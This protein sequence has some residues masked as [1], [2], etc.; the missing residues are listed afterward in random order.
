MKEI[1]SSFDRLDLNLLK[2]FEIV[3]RERSLSR[4]A[5]VLS[6]T[7]SAISH[8]LRRLR[9][10]FGDPLFERVGHK[11]VPTPLCNRIANDV[12]LEMARMRAMMQRW[13]YFDPEQSKG[14]LILG[15]PDALEGVFIPNLAQAIFDA[16]PQLTLVSAAIQRRSLA[17]DL[18]G[19]QFDVAIDVSLPV[20][21][22][23][24][25]KPLF[26]SDWCMVARCDHL[27]ISR[28]TLA[29]YENGKHVVVSSRSFG[30][31]LEDRALGERSINRSVQLRCQNYTTAIGGLAQTDLVLTMPRVLAKHLLGKRSDLCMVPLPVEMPEL[32]LFLYWHENH[33][34][35][36]RSVWIRETIT[37]VSSDL[38]Q[39][40]LKL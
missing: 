29:N 3:H 14:K 13:S 37:S 2:V 20:Q 6:L 15:M 8:A 23:V 32:R 28:P 33:D 31:V 35:D 4:A 34:S 18:Q 10:H 24:F 25:R 38:F 9:Q 11:M 39:S 12:V 16:A 30:A 21:S 5:D 1:H 19:G 36:K 27:A 26:R 7:P 22:D 40:T 17:L